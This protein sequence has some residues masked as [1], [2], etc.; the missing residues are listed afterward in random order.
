MTCSQILSTLIE[1]FPDEWPCILNYKDYHISRVEEG[2]AGVMV[3]FD[4]GV[5]ALLQN[6]STMGGLPVYRAEVFEYRT[7]ERWVVSSRNF[8]N[9]LMVCYEF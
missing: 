9:L 4:N 8:S 1:F 5:I 6:A 3:G 7:G 2:D